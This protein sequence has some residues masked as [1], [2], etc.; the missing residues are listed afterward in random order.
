MV[1]E[2]Y[3]VWWWCGCVR[4]SVEWPGNEIWSSWRMWTKSALVF[5]EE[6]AFLCFFFQTLKYDYSL[7]HQMFF[8][9]A[10]TNYLYGWCIH[11]PTSHVFFF[12]LF[13]KK[14]KTK[15]KKTFI[16]TKCFSFFHNYSLRYFDQTKISKK[17]WK[18]FEYQSGHSPMWLKQC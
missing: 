11:E 3:F 15:T 12:F 1:K 9:Y 16:K 10:S 13:F 14:N 2:L 18:F 6:A 8:E 7:F 17:H 4:F 5:F